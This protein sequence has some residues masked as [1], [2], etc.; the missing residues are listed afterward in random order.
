MAANE[1]SSHSPGAGH[2]PVGPLLRLDDDFLRQSG[3]DFVLE[4]DDHGQARQQARCPDA[5]QYAGVATFAMAKVRELTSLFQWGQPSSIHTI[6]VKL[7]LGILPYADKTFLLGWTPAPGMLPEAVNVIFGEGAIDPVSST[8]PRLPGTVDV[9]KKIPGLH[10]YLIFNKEN[11]VL[12]KRFSKDWSFD[13]LQGASRI[14]GQWYI[15]LQLQKLAFELAQIRFAV[16]SV[17]V[18]PAGDA[19][20]VVICHSQTKV[21]LLKDCMLRIGSAEIN[22]VLL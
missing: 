8:K 17:L 7:E 13:L 1:S 4:I 22:K 18:R 9:M 6:H 19:T 20:L 10:G 11:Q 15:A 12:V 5:K 14:I 21:P 3:V 2:L 16:G